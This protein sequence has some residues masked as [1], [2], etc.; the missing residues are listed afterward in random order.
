[1]AKN[2]EFPTPHNAGQYTAFNSALRQIAEPS[3]DKKNGG[4]DNC[5]PLF[6]RP[7]KTDIDDVA[8]EKQAKEDAIPDDRLLWVTSSLSAF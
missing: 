2:V 8:D 6:P 7:R 3:G 5:G 1:M 4:A